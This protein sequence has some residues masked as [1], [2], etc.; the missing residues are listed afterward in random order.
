[1]RNWLTAESNLILFHL[2][3]KPE[4]EFK[5]IL[6]P[7]PWEVNVEPES[8]LLIENM[9]WRVVEERTVLTAT[10]LAEDNDD[11][12]ITTEILGCVLDI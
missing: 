2:N 5:L 3:T 12:T 4:S 10:L 9:T 11:G 1:M 8:V 7:D 6:G